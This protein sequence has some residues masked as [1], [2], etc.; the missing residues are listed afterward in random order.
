MTA[1]DRDDCPGVLS[2]PLAG[3]AAAGLSARR[4]GAL[5]LRSWYL[6][7][8]S[9]PRLLDLLYWPLVQMIL[10]G[11]INQFMATQSGWV[12]RGGGV[13]IAA[14]LLW[15][16]L[17]RGQLN[18][19][20]TFLEEM[21][22]RNLAN[23]FVTPL[24]TVEWMLALVGVSLLRTTAGVLPAALIA[25][26]F[27]GYSVFE[28]GPALIF[29]YLNLVVMGWSLGL[30]VIGLILRFGMGAESLAWII[31]FAF[32]PVSAVYYPVSVLPEWLQ[33]VA[34]ALPST[35]SFEGMR[36]V[37]FDGLIPWNRIA[38]GAVLNVVYMGLASAAFLAFFRD[39]RRRGALLQT[40]E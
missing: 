37:V 39:A 31:V 27:F 13:L 20:V 7:R 18:V 38:A 5:M 14:V 21:W 24:R 15:D 29:L 6:M 25:I 35:H 19:S 36:A 33:W 10:W 12:A 4:V 32:A 22:S 17:V 3:P 8:G 23:L 1:S 2:A 11:F 40:G 30:V 28:L 34:L 26:P 16:V 9:V